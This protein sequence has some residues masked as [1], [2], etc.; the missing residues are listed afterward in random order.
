MGIYRFVVLSIIITVLLS[1]VFGLQVTSRERNPQFCGSPNRFRDRGFYSIQADELQCNNE[2]V[3]L[4][5]PVAG[6]VDTLLPSRKPTNV[7][8]KFN[9]TLTGGFSGIV[10]ST[11]APTPEVSSSSSSSSTTSSSSSST[12]STTTTT[13][14]TTVSPKSTAT[15]S[16]AIDRDAR[17]SLRV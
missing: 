5:G 8:G 13:T 17:K 9:Q 1:K 14:S 11:I 16:K 6:V 10:T 2:D 4:D 15:V 3:D 12:T 7:A